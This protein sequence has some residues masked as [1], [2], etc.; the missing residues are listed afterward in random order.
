M[1]IMSYYRGRN[2]NLHYYLKI[3]NQKNKVNL[4]NQTQ[5]PKNL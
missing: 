4:L 2:I 1:E 3:L 5:L